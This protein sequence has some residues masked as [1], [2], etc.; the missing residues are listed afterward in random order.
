VSASLADA[1]FVNKAKKNQPTAADGDPF[2]ET[3]AP[4]VEISPETAANILKQNFA[5]IAKKSDAGKSLSAQEVNLVQ[6]IKEGVDVS[7]P[8]PT[9]ADNQVALAKAL[10]VTRKTIQRWLKIE[11]NPGPEANGKW[12]VAKWKTFAA[13]KGHDFGD[14]IG[15]NKQASAKAEQI[16]LQN[17]KLRDGI[18][19]K[20]GELIPKILAKQVCS[21][22]LLSVKSRTFTS[23]NQIVMLARM[24]PDTATASEEIQKEL[25]TIWK[26][27]EDSKWLK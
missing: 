7:K 16:L 5:N 4:E 13:S 22:L 3:D 12:N 24:A 15:G 6:Q 25:T 11:G 1:F 21:K 27:F 23:I 26:T 18:L 8:L 19:Q 20:R 14:D 10:G 2:A 9:W 17:E